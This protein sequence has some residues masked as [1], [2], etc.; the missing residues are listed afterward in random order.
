MIING[1]ILA[2]GNSSRLGQPKQLVKYNQKYLINSIES[3]LSLICDNVFVV[4]G[5]YYHDIAQHIKAAQII[6]NKEWQKGMH[7]SLSLGVQQARQAA[8]GILIALSD[9]PLITT[10]HYQEL[11]EK[12]KNNPNKI[13]ASQYA[14]TNGVPAVFP[15]EFFDTMQ[16]MDEYNKGAQ[17]V[18]KNNKQHVVSIPCEDAAIDLDTPEQ[19][20]SLLS[21]SKK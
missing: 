7:T 19:L 13:I 16:N 5:A 15:I 4:L 21:P 3:Q 9:Q 2:A 18:I 6:R 17:S 11:S 14:Q 12:F 10:N 8:G 1:L 20:K